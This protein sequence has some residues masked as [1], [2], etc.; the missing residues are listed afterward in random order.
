MLLWN[1]IRLKAG[2]HGGKKAATPLRSSIITPYTAIRPTLVKM[3]LIPTVPEM[4]GHGHDL[5]QGKW[6]MLGNGPEIPNNEEGVIPANWS[7][8]KSAGGCGNCTIAD[9]C[10][11]IMEACKNAGV[12]IPMFT[13]ETAVLAYMART[14]AAN[15]EAYNPVNNTGD[16][17]LN[18]QD[19]IEWLLKE[20]ILD[21][22]GVSHKL[23]Y[24]LGLGAG[25]VQ[26]L[27][28][29]AF[30]T[31]KVK[32][33]LIL[34]EAQMQQFDAGPQP[35]WDYVAGS[36]EIGGHDTP[37]V[38]KLGLLSW[39]DD[40]YYTPRFIEK[41][42]DEAYGVLHPEQFPNGGKDLEGYDDG[43]IEKIMVGIASQKLAAI[44]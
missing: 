17:G 25:N 28:E 31:E 30:F 22:S 13:I 2:L 12:S 1:S 38:G 34:C 26:H 35:T 43:D 33:G 9:C 14:K 37:V 20:G 42:S 32:L 27:W 8:F 5:P 29:M 6:K 23:L 24:A 40:V 16:T 36:P 44:R 7:G 10:H 19:V 15:G 3:G 21:A 41:Q 39:G 18:I 4:F 11:T